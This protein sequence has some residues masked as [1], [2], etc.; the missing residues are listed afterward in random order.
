MYL[1]LWLDKQIYIVG[2]NI[3][4]MYIETDINVGDTLQ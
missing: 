3:Q 2:D 4:Y 1:I